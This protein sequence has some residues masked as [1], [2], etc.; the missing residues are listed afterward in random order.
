MQKQRSAAITGAGSGLGRE[1]ALGLAAK[2]Y[3]VFGTAIANGEIADLQQASGGKVALSICD[4]TDEKSVQSWARGFSD[5]LGVAGLDLLISNAGIL[6]PGPIE[7]LP[8]A[9]IRRE[10][11][12]DVFSAISVIHSRPQWHAEQRS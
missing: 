10:F 11:E 4:I 5:T 12:V 6:T 7:I 9:A 3:R 8:L 1:I 2:G